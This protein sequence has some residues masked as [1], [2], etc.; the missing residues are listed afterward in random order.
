[1]KRTLADR[2]L[3]F[4]DEYAPY[5]DQAED[6]QPENFSEMLY[7]LEEIQKDLDEDE[8]ELHRYLLSLITQFRMEGVKRNDEV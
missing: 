5:R 6:P 8:A 3:D 4:M 1:M 7:N 2:Y